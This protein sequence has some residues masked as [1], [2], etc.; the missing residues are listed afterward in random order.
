MGSLAVSRAIGTAMNMRRFIAVLSIAGAIL[1]LV[2]VLM[3]ERQRLQKT[4]DG[5]D[6]SVWKM[7]QYLFSRFKYGILAASLSFVM[8]DMYN[9]VIV[10]HRYNRQYFSA[11]ADGQDEIYNEFH[12]LYVAI[13][14]LL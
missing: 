1:V 5:E 13:K 9:K 8:L 7:I 2:A 14:K 11:L 3:V 12:N 10:I 4:N 6:K